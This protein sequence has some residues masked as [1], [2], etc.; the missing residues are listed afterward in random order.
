ML[1]TTAM[2]ASTLA[3]EASMAAGSKCCGLGRWDG[4]EAL[5]GLPDSKNQWSVTGRVC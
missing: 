4:Q 3:D 5:R 1:Q 2:G